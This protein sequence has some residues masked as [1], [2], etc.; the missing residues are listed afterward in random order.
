VAAN[1]I[2]DRP[3]E[4][5]PIVLKTIVGC[6][7][8]RAFDYFTRDIGRWWPLARYSC[9]EAQAQDVRFEPCVGG[10]LIET[11]KAG[12]THRWGTVSAWQRGERVAFSWHPGGD[13][14][15]AMWVDVAF[16]ANP[17][18]TL[19]TLTHGGFEALGDRAAT[20]KRAYENGWPTVFGELYTKYCEQANEEG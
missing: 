20:V 8:D 10:G 11:T 1:D 15:R 16:D 6:P 7:P 18:G 3:A 14:Q 19:V 5:V 4:S 12:A 13:P 9:G 17:A 2:A